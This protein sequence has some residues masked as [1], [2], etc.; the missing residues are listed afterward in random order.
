MHRLWLQQDDEMDEPMHRRALLSR[1]TT[2]P[3]PRPSSLIK[4]FS[5][6]TAMKRCSSLMNPP[7]KQSL[8]NTTDCQ[9][10]DGC[11]SS[12]GGDL[13]YSNKKEHDFRLGQRVCV[14][15]HHVV[16]TV[17]YFGETKFK[18]KG[19]WVGIELDLTGSGKNDGSIQG[20]RYFSCAPNTGLFVLATKVMALEDSQKKKIVPHISKTTAIA[21]TKKSHS[22]STST[23]TANKRKS[24][25]VTSSTTT[26]TSTTTTTNATSR[27]TSSTPKRHR[28][29]TTTVAPL[30]SSKSARTLPTTRSSKAPLPTRSTPSGA[31]KKMSTSTRTNKPALKK[32]SSMS[33]SSTDCHHHHHRSSQQQQQQQQEQQQKRL[34]ADVELE[35]M[36]ALLE[37]SRQEKRALSQQMDS[38][39]AAWERL[40]SAKESYAVRVQEKDDEI[41]RLK[42]LLDNSSQA[43]HELAKMTSE[44]DAALSRASMSEAM[45][46]QHSK[47]IERLDLRVRTLQQQLEAQQQHHEAVQRDHAAQMDQVRKQLTERDEAAALVERECSELRLGHV[48]T[49]RAFETTIEQRE[50]EYTTT[51]ANK[52]THIDK[53]QLMIND[54]MYPSTA[55]PIAEDDSTRRRLEAQ[56][57]LTTSELDKERKL[58]KAQILEISHLKDEI[59][60]LHRVSVCSSSE[61]YQLRSELEHEIEDKRRIM[62][63]ANAA[64]EVQARLEE[65]NERIKLTNEKTQRDLADVLRKLATTEK[66]RGSADLLAK[67]SQLE[68]ET[69]RLMSEKKQTEHECMRLMDELLAIEKVESSATQDVPDDDKMYRREIEQLKLQVNREVRK[70]QDL[71]QSKEAKI[72]KLYKEL[73]DLESLVENKVFNETELEEAIESEKR[74]VRMLEGRLRE[75]EEKNRRLPIHAPLSPTSPQYSLFNRQHYHHHQQK[76]SSTGSFSLMTSTSMDTVSDH[77]NLLESVYC[78]ICEEYGHEV[79]ACNAYKQKTILDEGDDH[80]DSQSSYYC[81]NCDVFDTHPTEECPN[82]DETF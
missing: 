78:E 54:L 1:A 9:P 61:F 20:V 32:S 40:V 35:R 25:I 57:E 80:Y 19:V 36:H 6:H 79:M 64:L 63:E 70:Y 26:S 17:R 65:E 42:R 31:T 55:S 81:V 56:L 75:E 48:K 53:L 30:N 77:G 60:R 58:I 7:L 29:A 71:E 11:T 22:S 41:A 72:H 69:E 8:S 51:V 43:T 67:C 5:D 23:S 66:E 50:R 33:T 59:K 28:S 21:T 68:A 76:R 13:V 52:D 15:S 12:G 73:S 2:T 47:V 3:M 10:D 62:E 82:Q 18:E 24:M 38:Q 34:S 4:R 49:I 37:K 14:P 39:E 44:R 27:S 16:G 45:E 74:K 46:K